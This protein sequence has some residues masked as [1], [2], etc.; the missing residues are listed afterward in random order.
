MFR[1]PPSGGGPTAPRISYGR[2]G[3]FEEPDYLGVDD[4][5]IIWWDAEG[6][7]VDE[8][9][10]EGTGVY[11]YADGGARYLPGEITQGDPGVFEREDSVALL[12]EPAPG[13]RPP[14]YP[15]PQRGAGLPAG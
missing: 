10:N 9:G 14:D 13:D 7:G 6:I 5:T 11:R 15:A 8:A 2:H 12:D 1:Y 4:S 3:V